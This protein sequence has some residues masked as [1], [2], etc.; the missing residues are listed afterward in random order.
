LVNLQCLFFKHVPIFWILSGN[1]GKQPILFQGDYPGL[2]S[3]LPSGEMFFA[4]KG[5]SI[6]AQGSHPGT[7]TPYH[8]DFPLKGVYNM[9]FSFR[10]QRGGLP[11]S[12]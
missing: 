11:P 8:A 10:I 12:G 7:K 6:L 4:L 5:L 2:I 9:P 1:E 3:I